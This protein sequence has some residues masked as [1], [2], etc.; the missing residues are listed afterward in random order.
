MINN[1]SFFLI[2]DGNNY[3]NKS[4]YVVSAFTNKC[5][6]QN[7]GTAKTAL[8]RS[9]NWLNSSYLSEENKIQDS[10]SQH[11]MSSITGINV[12]DYNDT[13]TSD[14]ILVNLL[15]CGQKVSIGTV[16]EIAWARAFQIPVVI[17]MEEDNIHQHA[18]L[19][20]G[21]IIVPTLEEGLQAII[22]ILKH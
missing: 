15:D 4:S 8:T 9:I 14:A 16:M 11:T 7:I 6:Y 17:V 13:K 3:V 5:I 18:M 19:S 1:L 2:T 12:R 10:Y 20:F 21:N 22:Q